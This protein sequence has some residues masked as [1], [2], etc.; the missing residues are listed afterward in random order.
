MICHAEANHLPLAEPSIGAKRTPRGPL[1]DQGDVIIVGA[2]PAG[3]AAA[4]ELARRGVRS[5]VLEAAEAVG[6]LSRTYVFQGHRFDVGG[7]RFFTRNEQVNSLWKEIL[8]EEFLVRKRLSRIY[9]RNHL[10]HYP[11]KP[12]NALAGLGLWTSL[13]S[14]LSLLR[15]RCFPVRP[16]RTFPDWVINR[17][18]RV[19]YEIFFKTY[20]EKVWGIPHDQLS[21]DWAAQRIRNLSLGRAILDAF[22]FRAPGRVASLIGEFRY[23]RHGPGQ[24]YEALARRVRES[25]SV[26]LPGRPVLEIRHDRGRVVSVVTP[27]DGGREERPAGH[28][29]S[30]MPLTDLMQ[31]MRPR[32]PDR[33][34]EMAA[35]L[36]YRAILAVNLIVNRENLA[37]DTWIY[38]H[39]PSVRAARLQFYRNWSP[40]MTAD[41]AKN[42]VSL[43][44]F[45]FEDD[46]LWN[47]PDEVLI[48]LAREELARLSFAVPEEIEDGF[49]VRCPK[50]YPVYEDEYEA[51]VAAFREWLSGFSNLQCIGRS[52]QFRYNNMD[53]SILT[54]LLAARRML[55]EDLDPWSVNEE[56]EYIE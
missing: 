50:A 55:G 37:P 18:G 1:T 53:H 13:R 19:L 41:P 28:L 39:A 5:V 45:C 47:S 24:M 6:G 11:L 23:P 31:R 15:A 7:H 30:S 40:H 32:A 20:T 8:G 9:Y 34:L 36:R 43:E 4:Y 54:G 21:A 29:I 27:S 25:G 56:A 52:G 42:P 3:L 51:K 10:F 49:V 38:L 16:E 2:G 35:A 44:Y 14:L 46:D 48:D 17:F 26:V 33:L 12:L 22:G